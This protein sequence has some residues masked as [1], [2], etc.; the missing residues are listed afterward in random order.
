MH[1]VGV[2]REEDVRL[3]DDFRRRFH[4]VEDGPVGH[5]ALP[6]GSEAAIKGHLERGGVAVTLIEYEAFANC[7]A[8]TALI[9]A[10][11]TMASCGKSILGNAELVTVYVNDALVSDYKAA[12]NWSQYASRIKGIS[13]LSN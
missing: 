9:L 10:S 3:P 4:S 2:E 6:S 11:T 13:E 5:V 12:T 1:S 8:L 7:S